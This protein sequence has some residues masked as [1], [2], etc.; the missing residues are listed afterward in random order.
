M[1]ISKNYRILYSTAGYYPAQTKRALIRSVGGQPADLLD[2]ERCIVS[3]YRGDA[4]VWSGK[5]IYRGFSFGIELWE[6]DFSQVDQTGSF[7]LRAD[8]KEKTGF[9]GTLASLTFPIGEWLFSDTILKELSICNAESRYASD[10]DKNGYYDCNTEMGES[11]SHGRYLYGL[12]D[13]WAARIGSLNSWEKTRLK[14]A[15]SCAFDYLYMLWRPDGEIA[16][17][18]PTRFQSDANPGIHNSYWSVMGLLAHINLFKENLPA[19]YIDEFYKKMEICVTYLEAHGY[20]TESMDGGIVPVYYY[21]YQHRGDKTWL[22]KAVLALNSQCEKFDLFRGLRFA[23]PIT[24]GLSLLLREQPDHPDAKRWKEFAQQLAT[25]YFIHLRD[26][27]AFQTMPSLG[28]ENPGEQWVHMEREPLGSGNLWGI[29][30]FFTSLAANTG[31]DA[32]NLIRITGD[33]SL[34]KVAS[35]CIGWV[36]GINPGMP[37]WAVANPPAEQDYEAAALIANTPFRH[38]KAWTEWSFAMRNPHWQ[39]VPNGYIF[40]EKSVFEYPDQWQSAETFIATDGVLLSVLAA[41]E[42][43]MEDCSLAPV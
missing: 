10:T 36:M 4:L 32:I 41:Y 26:G 28:G 6:I 18:W 20:N 13:Y 43:Y 16:H 38:A 35:G 19:E 22:D 14:Q 1:D 15:M 24:A 33:I 3:L 39:S 2:T 12:A 9:V 34:E 37:R 25:R 17:S 8:M 30:H 5:P 7:Q 23:A 42:D 11:F 29:R 40:K 21:L 31:Y 27:N